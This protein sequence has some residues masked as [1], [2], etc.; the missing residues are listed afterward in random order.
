MCGHIFFCN[1]A[2]DVLLDLAKLSGARGRV[3]VIPN[4]RTAADFRCFDMKLKKIF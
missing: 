3:D 4:G 2:D 1:N